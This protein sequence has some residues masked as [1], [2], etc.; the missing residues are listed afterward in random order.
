[1]SQFGPVPTI[2]SYISKIYFNIVH[3]LRLGLPSGIF[4]SGFPTNTIYAFLLSPIRATCQGKGINFHFP[5]PFAA[6]LTSPI[7][8]L[9]LF[10]F[11]SHSAKLYFL[12]SEKYIILRL[13]F[14]PFISYLVSPI[15]N[16]PSKFNLLQFQFTSFHLVLKQQHCFIPHH[17]VFTDL[18][19]QWLSWGPNP[20]SFSVFSSSGPCNIHLNPGTCLT[21]SSAIFK[22]TI[23]A[24][25]WLNKWRLQSLHSRLYIVFHHSQH[26]N[27]KFYPVTDCFHSDLLTFLAYIFPHVLGWN[28]NK[29]KLFLSVITR[30]IHVHIK[31]FIDFILQSHKFTYIGTR[32]WCR[33]Y[34]YH[35]TNCWDLFT[36][37]TWPVSTKWPTK[38]RT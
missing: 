21:V 3:P 28:M 18:S 25:Y 36:V 1:M 29:L 31:R 34:I 13:F 16:E 7:T 20:L 8:L 26:E 19:L 6:A 32:N 9:F 22:G 24:Y 33:Y 38:P 37:Q 35:W 11:Y 4:P 17:L 10:C 27:N 12:P 2:L 15:W 14:R 5:V 30:V 23:M